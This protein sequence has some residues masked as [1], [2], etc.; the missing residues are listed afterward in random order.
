MMSTTETMYDRLFLSAPATPA[1]AMAA[2][3]P[4]IVKP[5]DMVIAVERSTLKIRRAML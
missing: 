4:Q 1:V 5:L 3:A 2:E